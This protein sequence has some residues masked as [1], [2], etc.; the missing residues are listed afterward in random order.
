MTNDIDP[1][2]QREDEFLRV[3][4]LEYASK[5]HPDAIY[6][7]QSFLDRAAAIEHY[8]RT[9]EHELDFGTNTD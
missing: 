5:G 4:A 6:E 2:Q 7:T 1:D 8:I 3:Q 9:G